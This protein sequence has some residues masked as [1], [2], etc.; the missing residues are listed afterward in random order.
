MPGALAH[1]A[2]GGFPFGGLSE[3]DPSGFREAALLGCTSRSASLC[4]MCD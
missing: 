4:K 1:G 2:G 3:W